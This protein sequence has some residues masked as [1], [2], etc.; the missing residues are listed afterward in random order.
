[1]IHGKTISYVEKNWNKK[2]LKWNRSNTVYSVFQLATDIYFRRFYDNFKIGNLLDD[3]HP[4]LYV[5][6]FDHF[7]GEPILP[8]EVQEDGDRVEM[9]TQRLGRYGYTQ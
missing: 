1:M 6:L 4:P 3:A 2:T 5:Y 8:L 7:T 9:I